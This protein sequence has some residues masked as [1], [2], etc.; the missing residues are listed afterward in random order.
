MRSLFSPRVHIPGAIAEAAGFLASEWDLQM[1]PTRARVVMWGW[2][3][4]SGFVQ[5][6]KM[7]WW[8]VSPVVVEPNEIATKMYKQFFFLLV[9][10]RMLGEE[11]DF[12]EVWYSR[13]IVL[14]VDGNC[15][16]SGETSK[17]LDW[18][19]KA[20]YIA[21]SASST[22]DMYIDWSERAVQRLTAARTLASSHTI[23]ILVEI[24]LSM[25]KWTRGNHPGR[26]WAFDDCEGDVAVLLNLADYEIATNSWGGALE[27]SH[28]KWKIN[29]A[30]TSS[31][32]RGISRC[33]LNAGDLSA[34]FDQH[35]TEAVFLSHYARFR[36]LS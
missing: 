26:V 7:A 15:D 13:I 6:R 10:R 11:G 32:L 25:K 33:A 22:R 21:N 2:C 34:S 17:W 27:W 31:E 1:S 24:R 20:S 16:P 14:G 35:T 5:Q 18:A 23:G 4:N 36:R 3:D 30:R 8:W 12:T 9:K 29:R 19:S 28:Q